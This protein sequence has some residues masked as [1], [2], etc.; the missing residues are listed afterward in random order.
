MARAVDIEWPVF[1]HLQKAKSGGPIARDVVAD[2]AHI[3]GIE[4]CKRHKN[5]VTILGNQQ[6]TMQ[7]LSSQQNT[8]R[9][10]PCAYTEAGDKASVPEF[11]TLRFDNPVMLR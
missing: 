6:A 2:V 1:V 4:L 5:L 8:T 3:V 11:P 7:V 10:K 9:Y